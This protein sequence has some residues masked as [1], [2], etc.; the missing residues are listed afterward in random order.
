MDS[1]LRTQQQHPH[2][3]AL[4]VVDPC[5]VCEGIGG[6]SQRTVKSEMRLL[7]RSSLTPQHVFVCDY[8]PQRKA[9]SAIE[10]VMGFEQEGTR[11]WVWPKTA[12][13]MT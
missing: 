5:A 11:S 9:H 1:S 10:R 4:D 12:L 8:R 2:P 13:K 6:S 7:H 3:Q